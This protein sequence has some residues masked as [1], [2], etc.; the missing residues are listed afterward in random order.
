MVRSGKESCVIGSVYPRWVAKY[1]GFHFT[2]AS[3]CVGKTHVNVL[4]RIGVIFVIIAALI[5]LSAFMSVLQNTTAQAA[6]SNQLNFQGRILTSTGSLVPDGN[7]H[8]EFKLYYVSSGGTA[9]W[10]ETRSTGNLVNIKKGYYSV[11]LGAVT[12]FHTTIDWSEDLYLTMN[13]GGNSGIATWDG[14]MNPRFKLTSVPYAFRANSAETLSKSDSSFTSTLG[15][16]TPTQNNVI[17]L[18]N[19][20]GDVCLTSGNCAG[21]GGTGDILDG[22]QAGAISIGTTDATT[23]SLIQNGSAALT[24]NTSQLIQFNAYNCS[25]FTNGGTL[26][27]DASGNVI[28]ANDDGGGATGAPSGAQY[29][30]LALDAAL[31]DERVLTAGSNISI[32]DTGANGTL[33]V[34]VVSNPSFSG[35]LDVTQSVAFQRG[36]DYTTTG[37][38]NNVSFADASL[39]RLTGASAQTITGIAGGRNGELLTIINAGATTA[40]LTNE[41]ASS[42]AAN[43]ITT[44]TSANLPLPSGAS[45][46]LVYDS[47]ASRWRITSAV[48]GSSGSGATSVTN[49]TN[50]TGSIT[51][52]NLTL[53]WTGQLSVVRGG[54]GAATFIQNGVIYGNTTGSL[55]ATAAGTT[56]QVLIANASGIPTFVTLSGDI[57]INATGLATIAANAVGSSEIIDAAITGTDIAAGTVA[58]TNLVNSQL[59]VNTGSGL[60]GGGNISL[61]GARNLS[62]GD[63]SADWVQSGGFDI[64]LNNAGSQLRILEASGGL[65]Y[66][67]FDVADLNATRLYTFPDASG[68]VSVLG[69]TIE[70]SE[71]ANNIVTINTSSGIS[72]GG[73]VSLGGSLSLS[74]SLGADIDSTEIIDGTLLA[75]DYSTTNTLGAGVNGYVYTYNNATGNF[76]LV[77]AATIGGSGGVTTLNG[78]AGGL[79]VVGNTQLAVSAVGSSI[80]LSINADTITAGQLAANSVGASELASTA[81]G[82]GTYNTANQVRTFTPRFNLG[83]IPRTRSVAS[84]LRLQEWLY[85]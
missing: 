74:A 36:T 31:S 61:G 77:D 44:G 22:G 33:T 23:V 12:A 14:E 41:S 59:G 46:S 63:L 32:A 35:T 17:N 19:E 53:G 29:L 6:T 7:Y 69:Q 37:T 10:T 76:T 73:I 85:Y 57:T 3:F 60:Q 4:R 54:T 66:G 1:V 26:T 58:N 75:V 42:T 49:D 68:Q 28:C 38:T 67:E 81:V 47:G 2:L 80:N 13:V 27:T 25:T 78:L 15:I 8:L 50:V 56:G 55:Q 30:T 21:V 65:Y 39:I 16:T 83:V 79:S 48:A 72:G 34:N 82:A 64:V 45:I 5:P 24:V 9:Q 51:A 18:P 84:S 43:R 71:L 62:L 11:Y 40:S 52:N 20:S 70:N